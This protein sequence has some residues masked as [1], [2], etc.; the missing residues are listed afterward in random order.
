MAT[1]VFTNRPALAS[2][3]RRWLVVA[4]LWMGALLA[5]YSWLQQVWPDHAGRWLV[6][7]TI[8]LAYGLWMVWRNLPENQREGES[9]LLPALGAG[10]SLTLVRG[11]AIGLTAGFLFSPWPMAALAWAPVLLYTTADVADYFDGYLARV[12]NHAT[13]LGARLDMEFDSLGILVVSILAVWYGQL[14]WW[15]LILGSSRYLFILGIWWRQRQGKPVYALPPSVHRRV[16]AGFQMGFMSAVL[17]PIVPA[18]MA[19]VA[20]TVLA[21]ATALSFGRDWL[22]AS[23][24]LDP[25]S[26]SYRRG[27][28]WL[29]MATAKWL[30]PLLRLALVVA[31]I[32]IYQ[33]VAHWLRPPAWTALITS[34]RLPEPPILA[35]GLSVIAIVATIMAA[36]GVLGR[37][38]A[39]LLVFPIGFDVATRGLQW[40]NGVALVS[41]TSLMLLGMGALSLWRPGEKYL[42]RPVGETTKRKG[43]GAKG[44]GLSLASYFL[45]RERRP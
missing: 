3:H 34:W 2:L 14:P 40:D 27:Q 18:A 42:L 44:N 24:R 13:R 15:Y 6:I 17:W 8:C 4:A 38:V 7:A 23:G 31:M 28:R 41:V 29:F 11:L 37:L 25:A 39:F 36:I 30:P 16:F 20:G 12:T 1:T 5:G 9:I 32:M 19:T 33:N 10:N 21:T 35:A 22:V 26:P 43:R 45:H